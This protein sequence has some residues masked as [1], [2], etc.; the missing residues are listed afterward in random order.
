[1]A[2][3]IAA[4][5]RHARQDYSAL[6]KLLHWSTAGLVVFM[7]GLGLYMTRDDIDLTSKFQAYQLHKSI[8][9]T[10][11]ALT[12]I[13]FIAR[14]ATGV[15]ALPPHVAGWERA[16]A[17]A[18]H[19]GLYALLF[20]MTLTGW[21]MVSV[22]AFAIPTTL[23]GVIPWPHIPGLVDLAP[24]EK[25]AAEAVFKQTHEILAW[26][27]AGLIGVH[28]AAA[29]RHGL[30]LKDGV[31]SRMLPRFLKGSAALAGAALI[32]AAM[33]GEARAYEWDVARD[34]SRVGFEVSAAGQTVKGSFG[35]FQAQVRFDPELLA[36]AEV[37]F[38]VDIATMK[39]GAPD[40]DKTLATAE[41]F[42]VKNHPKAVFRAAGAKRV[43][44]GKYEMNGQLTVKG[45]TQP[46]VFPFALDVDGSDATAKGQFTVNRIAHGV[47]PE[48]V[49]GVPVPKE[50]VVTVDIAAL[51]LD[52]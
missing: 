28:V 41:W 21:A 38:A 27:L 42:D 18:A 46:A 1:M 19:G 51:K 23:Y 47:G 45:V 49:A 35:N 7:I 12:V 25:K 11:L 8:G 13:R 36:N 40:V 3:P 29:L 31:M 5:A 22:A 20:A 32:G 17:H 26:S 9:V 34:K 4:E 2:A 37:A 6:A 24:E 39:T 15:P 14:Q 16:A 44:D 33:L 30:I 48:S 50:I 52:N 43:G 10:I